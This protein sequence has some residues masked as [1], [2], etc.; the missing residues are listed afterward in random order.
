MCERGGRVCDG[1][2]GECVREEEEYVKERR[3]CERGGRVCEGEE[4]E[5]VEGGER[6]VSGGGRV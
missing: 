1:E 6:R 2:E 4:G 3:V 5:C